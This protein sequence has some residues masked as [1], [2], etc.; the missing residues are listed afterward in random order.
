MAILVFT[1]IKVA[2]VKVRAAGADDPSVTFKAKC[3]MCHTAKAEKNFDPAKGDDELVQTVL[4]GK[5]TEKPPLMPG[6]EAKGMT[7]E[8]A[9][10]MVTYMRSLRAPA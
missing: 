2:P 9:K 1:V 5:K 6:F 3:A 10:S 8:E 7:A 4:K